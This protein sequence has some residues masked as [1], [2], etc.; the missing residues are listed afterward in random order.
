[1]TPA[2]RRL[3][4]PAMPGKQK[5][6]TCYCRWEAKEFGLMRHVFMVGQKGNSAGALNSFQ[7]Q[8]FQR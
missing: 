6:P 3:G 2:F 4:L 7:H 1:V 8:R 5:A